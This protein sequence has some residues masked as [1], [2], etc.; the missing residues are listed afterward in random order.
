MGRE[1]RVE[2]ARAG[3]GLGLEVSVSISVLWAEGRESMAAAKSRC[4]IQEVRLAYSVGGREGGR[5][6]IESGQT[7]CL[8]RM[9]LRVFS[10]GVGRCLQT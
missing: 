4:F 10:S 2:Q 9:L 6:P 8:L 5:A 7:I 1:Q 3:V